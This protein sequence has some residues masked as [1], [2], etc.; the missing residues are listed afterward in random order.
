VSLVD[1]TDFSATEFLFYKHQLDKVQWILPFYDVL[2]KF[3]SAWS[4]PHWFQWGW[5]ITALVKK[6]CAFAVH[7]K[8]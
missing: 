5:Y 2:L 8:S 1:L 3:F 4:L 6:K 7:F